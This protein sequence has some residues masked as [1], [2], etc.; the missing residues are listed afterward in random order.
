MTC[1]KRGM[2]GGHEHVTEA[3]LSGR[4]QLGKGTL[5]REGPEVHLELVHSQQEATNAV[6]QSHS[7]EK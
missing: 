7:S 3:L 2:T 6:K 1:A 4:S 5:T